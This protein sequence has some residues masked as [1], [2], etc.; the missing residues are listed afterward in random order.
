MRA[1]RHGSMAAAMLGV[2]MWGAAATAQVAAGGGGEPRS[3]QYFSAQPPFDAGVFIAPGSTLRAKQRRDRDA[4]W[5]AEIRRELFV[6]EALPALQAH[7][8]STFSPVPGVLADRVTY[9]TADGMRVPAVV[10]RPDPAT[11]H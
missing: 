8:V 2:T 3:E 9:A 4:A 5:R 6:P 1:L 10:Y 7:A 11:Q